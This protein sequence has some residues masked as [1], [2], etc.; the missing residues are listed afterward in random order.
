M[1]CMKCGRSIDPGQVFCESCLKGME[2]Y[3]VRPGTPIT[4]PRRT[5]TPSKKAQP[6]RRALTHEE[7]TIIQRRTIK[8]LWIAL[9]CTLL[10]LAVSVVLMLHF[11]SNQEVHSNIGQNY[12]TRSVP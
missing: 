11:A 1:E 9:L 2:K 3:P 6:R 8:R 10:C 5:A 4:L 7:L 12:N